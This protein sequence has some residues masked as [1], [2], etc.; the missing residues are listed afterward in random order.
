MG[1]AGTDGWQDLSAK[2]Q[3]SEW[4][5]FLLLIFC[6]LTFSANAQVDVVKFNFIDNLINSNNDTT[7]IINFWATWCKPCVKELPYFEE[8]KENHKNEKVNITLVS[9]DFKRDAQNRV[10]PFVENNNIR[11]RV[12]LLDEPDYNSWINK[13]DSSWS[14]GIPA[15]LICQGKVKKI[16]EKEFNSFFELENSIK[17]FLE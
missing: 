11:N 9:L 17:P 10:A 7:Y 8:F 16:Y 15:T 5:L 1:K 4:F 3:E 13:V 14:G 2:V 12:V 6:S